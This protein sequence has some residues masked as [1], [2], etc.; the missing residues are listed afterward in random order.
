MIETF[1]P[2]VEHYVIQGYIRKLTSKSKIQPQYKP[3]LEKMKY[4]KLHNLSV[5]V[6]HAV[7]YEATR[8]IGFDN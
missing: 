8:K 6:A 3:Y 1:E 2:A 5:D 7:M 4:V